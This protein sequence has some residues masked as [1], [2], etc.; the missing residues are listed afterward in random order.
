VFVSFDH[1]DLV[2]SQQVDIIWTVRELPPVPAQWAMPS[3]VTWP[4]SSVWPQLSDASG[5]VL[6]CPLWASSL[7]E[8]CCRGGRQRYDRSPFPR[9]NFAKVLNKALH[10]NGT[11]TMLAVVISLFLV[12]SPLFAAAVSF[13]AQFSISRFNTGG[14]SFVNMT[15]SASTFCY[16]S[17]VAVENT[18]IEDEIAGC[19]VTR[20]A[21][22][23]VLEAFLNQSNDA[24]AH[25]SAI[26]YNN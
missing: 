15:P 24:D 16:L 9:A 4:S 10:M 14:S 21:V 22:V 19:R 12:L 18:D 25:C 20:G 23:W 8:S 13:R 1:D 26:C 5:K 2:T 6:R 17:R 3:T 7:A 11:R